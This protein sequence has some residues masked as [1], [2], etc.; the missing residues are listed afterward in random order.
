MVERVLLGGVEVAAGWVAEGGNVE[1]G[2]AREGQPVAGTDQAALVRT[3]DPDVIDD[4]Q[5]G[6]ADLTWRKPPE[7]QGVGRHEPVRAG[8]D[9]VP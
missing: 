2:P 7:R 4:Q 8:P 5:V 1:E 3:G 9:S 6:I